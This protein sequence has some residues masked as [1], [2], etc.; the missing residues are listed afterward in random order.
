MNENPD[1]V[2]MDTYLV[3]NSFHLQ[4]QCLPNKKCTYLA[5]VQAHGNNFDHNRL[6]Y[7]LL[8]VLFQ[9]PFD[10]EYATQTLDDVASERAEHKEE[11][12]VDV[13]FSLKS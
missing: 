3:G 1:P 5:L 13:T 8:N 6:C 9:T 12:C 10:V 2:D 11:V 4:K 7:Y